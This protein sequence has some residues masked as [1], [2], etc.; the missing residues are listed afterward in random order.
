M[1]KLNVVHRD[2]KLDNILRHKNTDG[3][4]ILKIAD[5]G[6]AKELD[7]TQMTKTALGTPITK[8]PE[9]LEKKTYGL[10]CDLYSLGVVFYQILFGNYPFAANNEFI[11]LEKIKEGKINFN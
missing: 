9:I 5:L 3:D 7:E 6:F 2:I 10:E 11:L 8:A 4:I 1:H